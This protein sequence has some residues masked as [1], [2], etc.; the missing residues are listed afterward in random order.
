MKTLRTL[1]VLALLLVVRPLIAADAPPDPE[2]AKAA[3]ALKEAQK[4]AAALKYQQGT[5]VLAQ[6]LAKIAL[7]ANYRYLDPAD[8]ETV[9]TKFWGNPS[10]KGSLGMIVPEGFDPL[11]DNNWAA[12]LSFSEDGYVKDDDAAKI[13]YDDLL[14]QMKKDV[15]ESN[16]ERE[17]AGYPSIELIGWAAPPR[18]DATTHKLYW[19][20]ELKFGGEKDHTLNYNIRMLGRRGVLV[21]NA[22]AGI[23]QLKQVEAATPALLAMTDFQEGHRYADFN[24]DTDKVATYGLAAL[25]AGG[26]AAKAGIFKAL[27]LGILAFKKLIIIGVIAI[28]S[29]L[30]KLW[31]WIRGRQ[32]APAIATANPP[33]NPPSGTA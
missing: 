26:V 19:A 32:A 33:D 16:P 31:A 9:L 6:G 11:G 13:N 20:K 4:A 3:A 17:K 22:V 14:K 30:G 28:G 7:P 24:D 12:I 27:W 23:D 8:S 2:A 15:A 25:V 21:M 29:Q 1:P 18:Y 10:G 5:V